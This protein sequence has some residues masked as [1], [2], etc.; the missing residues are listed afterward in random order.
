VEEPIKVVDPIV[1]RVRILLVTEVTWLG[2]TSRKSVRP[3][4]LARDV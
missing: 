2:R 4:L 1:E 3:V